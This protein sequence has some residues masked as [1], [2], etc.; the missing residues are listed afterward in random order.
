MLSGLGRAVGVPGVHPLSGRGALS[1]LALAGLLTLM[2]AGC[3]AVRSEPAM[4]SSPLTWASPVRA[5]DQPPFLSPGEIKSVSCLSQSLCFAVDNEGDVLSSTDPTGGTGAWRRVYSD[6]SAKLRHISC[7]SIALCVAVGRSGQI[8]TSTEPTGGAWTPIKVGESG[9]SEVSCPS[10]SLCVAVDETEKHQLLTSTDPAGGVAAWSTTE[11]TSPRRISLSGVS[12]PTNKLCVASGYEGYLATSTN[13]TGGAGA[14]A[15]SQLEP[16]GGHNLQAVSCSS[17]SLCVL[18]DNVGDALVSTEPTGGDATWKLSHVSDGLI[19]RV[20]CAAWGLCVAL[21]GNKV[22]T[23]LEPTGGEG[24]WSSATLELKNRFGGQNSLEAAACPAADLCVLGDSGGAVLTSTEPTGG[25]SAW[26][27]T[28]LEVGSSGTWRISCAS[29]SLCVGADEG[30]NVVVSTDPTAGGATWTKVHLDEHRLNGVS[31]PSSGLCVVG[32][33]AG[34]VLMSTD[35]AGGASAWNE[36]N[37]DGA[38]PIRGVSCPSA[39]LCVAIDREGDV[40]TSTHP[41]GGSGAWSVAPVPHVGTLAGVS[42][43][44]EQLCVLVDTQGGVITSTDPTGGTEAWTRTYAEVPASISCP[45]TNLCVTAGGGSILASSNPTGGASTWR[46][47]YIEGLNGLDEISCAPG[48]FCVATSYGG[49]GSPG[50]VVVA[51]DLAGTLGTWFKSNVYGVP[52]EPPNPMLELKADELTGVSCVPEGMCAVAD[53]DGRVMIGTPS[54]QAPAVETKRASAVTQTTTT[55]NGTVNPEGSEVT[56]CKFEYGTSLSYGSSVPCSV[57]PGSGSTP[58]AVSAPVSGLSEDTAYHVRISATSAAGTSKGSDETFKTLPTCMVE[59][60]CASFTHDEAKGLPFG[61]PTAVA[62]AASGN[63]YVADGTRFHDRVLEF[64]AKHEYLSQFGSPGTGEGQLNQI[65]GIAL[66]SAG[67]LYVADTANNR[68]EEFGPE[69][70]YLAK[71]GSYGSGNGQLDSP[72]AVAIDSGGDV[73]VADALNSRVEEFSSTGTYIA[74][75]GEAGTAPG[76]LGWVSGLALSGGNVYLVE[77]YAARVQEFS[78]AGTFVSVFDEKGSGTGKSNVPYGI[79]TDAASGNL[80]VVEGASILA[81]ASANRVQEFTPEGV[82]VTA[83]G[84]SGVGT[85][86]L[87]GPRGLAVGSGQIFVADSGNKRLEEWAL[88]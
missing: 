38:I 43:P 24:T 67:D 16:E 42:C 84:S 50:N 61:E 31:C 49:N 53:I 33:E 29:E 62:V 65:G 68:V 82:F 80:Y 3:F 26:T 18:T 37:V 5:D 23:S 10:T 78:T 39:N 48:G 81:G 55:L 11:I 76:K 66:N 6:S 15:V 22:I 60:F 74:Q 4:A 79:A 27:L 51:S 12:C 47:T 2:L 86:Q 34:N 46:E 21:E 20:S 36:A 44:S 83:F 69:G 25:A 41:T 87:A 88:P 35:P 70:K 19:T 1:A 7:P 85:G 13:P 64:N 72:T 75:F 58:V 52:I 40:V 71:F 63:I 9:I 28:P 54:S 14:W 77:P 57:L 59:G 17:E 73:W 30:G 45:S 8:L 56:E 32:D